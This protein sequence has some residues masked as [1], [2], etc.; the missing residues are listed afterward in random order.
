MLC[1]INVDSQA[2]SEPDRKVRATDETGT[3]SR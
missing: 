2:D 1:I 3:S